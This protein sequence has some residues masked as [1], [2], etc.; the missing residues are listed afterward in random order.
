MGLFKD[1][2]QRISI[3]DEPHRLTGKIPLLY[4]TGG[5]TAE[6]EDKFR[7]MWMKHASETGLAIMGC[8]PYKEED[9]KITQFDRNFDRRRLLLI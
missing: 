1:V 2:I 4:G 8:D 6:S 7:E 5:H 3:K 9:M